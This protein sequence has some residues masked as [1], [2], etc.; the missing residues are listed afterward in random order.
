MNLTYLKSTGQL[1]Y[2]MTLYL[3]LS[4][5]SSLLGW[6]YTFLHTEYMHHFWISQ[7]W[8][9][10]CS[11]FHRGQI[12]LP[13]LLPS[14]VNLHQVSVEFLPYKAVIFP[15]LINE[16]SG[17]DILRL[18]RHRVSSQT[19][20]HNFSMYHGSCLQQLLPNDDFLLSSFPLHL[21]IGTFLPHFSLYSTTVFHWY[22]V[23]I[24]L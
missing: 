9:A 1:S 23:Y 18:C 22:H 11:L 20:A 13:C 12:M 17:G 10:L 19:F 24:V 2:R 5:V 6:G 15:F 4:D 7:K 21:L 3:G 14:A 8:C 16:Y